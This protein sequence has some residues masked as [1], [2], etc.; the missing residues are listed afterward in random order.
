MSENAQFHL[1]YSKEKL[2]INLFSGLIFFCSIAAPLSFSFLIQQKVNPVLAFS[3]GVSFVF[4]L[5]VLSFL[6]S[7]SIKSLDQKY[8]QVRT[9]TRLKRRQSTLMY[10]VIQESPKFL[11]LKN[12]SENK[13]MM[14]SKEKLRADFE[15]EPPA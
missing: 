1:K 8:S 5:I 13:K 7:N 12:T 15:L 6:R 3:I 9:G 2:K 10:E 11:Y 14:I 4:F